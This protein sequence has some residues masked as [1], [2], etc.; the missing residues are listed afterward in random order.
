MKK[1][2]VVVAVILAAIALILWVA[3]WFRADDAVAASAALEWPGG[4]GTLDSVAG[5]LPERKAND[6]SVK[7]TALARALPENEAVVHFVQRE[8]I[9][10]ELA[11]GEAPALPD[12]S[13]IRELLLNEPVVWERRHEIGSA[14]T[15]ENRGVQMTV[16]RALVASALAKARSDD[17][18]G[19]EELRAVWN[20]SR[21]LDGHTQVMEQTAALSM[22]RMINA[23]AWKMPL[24]APAW[25]VEFQQHDSLRPLLE[26]FQDQTA[27]YWQSGAQLFPT[28]SLAD[29]VE[30]D[31]LIAE[32]LF[33]TTTCDVNIRMNQLGTDLTSVWRRAFRYRAEREATSNALLVRMGSP[34]E[35]AS[36]CSDGE[37]TFDGTTLRFNRE[38]PTAA[39]DT[40][41]PLV[42]Q[43]DPP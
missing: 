11:I 21:S 8:M 38:I 28:K 24:P 4:M 16:A 43:I 42:L 26:A 5:R 12:V 15:S 31:R 39:P 1:A 36:R 9:R 3:T 19:W 27:S 40:P 14:V 35:T 10:G 17:A 33:N 34:I 18:A 30:H 25:L 22:V 7:L 2:L 32:E 6:A 37:W 23:I 13:L 29:S 41:M 20:L